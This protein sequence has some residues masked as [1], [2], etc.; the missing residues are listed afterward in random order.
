MDIKFMRTN[1]GTYQSDVKIFSI[2]LTGNKRIATGI[3]RK[4][5][6]VDV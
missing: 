1:F 6:L 3:H 2:P 5:R 4:Y